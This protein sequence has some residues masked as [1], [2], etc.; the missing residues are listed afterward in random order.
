MD[1]PLRAMQLQALT[2]VSLLPPAPRQGL[3]LV[4]RE[5]LGERLRLGPPT[6]NVH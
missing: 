2:P 5:L 3:E 4:L 1:L 6:G